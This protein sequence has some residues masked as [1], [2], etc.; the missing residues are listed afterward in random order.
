MWLLG[1][2][3]TLDLALFGW[4]LV[5]ILISLLL[6]ASEQ[7]TPAGLLPSCVLIA[8][9]IFLL[10]LLIRFLIVVEAWCDGKIIG[11]IGGSRERRRLRYDIIECLVCVSRVLCKW[12]PL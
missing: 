7:P 4:V 11:F 2:F 3:Y 12:R 9:L 1:R 10:L 6:L 5:I 8:I